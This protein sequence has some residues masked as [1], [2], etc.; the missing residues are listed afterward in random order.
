MRSSPEEW[1]SFAMRRIKAC[2]CFEIGGRPWRWPPNTRASP[3]RCLPRVLSIGLWP[4]RR[5]RPDVGR[6]QVHP[7]IEL[8]RMYHPPGLLERRS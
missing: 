1:F 5:L 4:P 3:R 7:R 6:A 8:L 2:N